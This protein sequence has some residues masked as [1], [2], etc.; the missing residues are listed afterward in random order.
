LTCAFTETAL[1]RPAPTSERMQIKSFIRP[2]QIIPRPQHIA[3]AAGQCLYLS[4]CSP[5]LA[6]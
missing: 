5:E 1:Q 4:L 6:E 3:A 2:P